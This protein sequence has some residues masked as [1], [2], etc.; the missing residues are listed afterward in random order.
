MKTYA[1]PASYGD[2]HTGLPWIKRRKRHGLGGGTGHA[3]SDCEDE[4][5]KLSHLL[6][7]S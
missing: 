1:A 3:E 5:Q 6:I 2:N 4:R 7:S